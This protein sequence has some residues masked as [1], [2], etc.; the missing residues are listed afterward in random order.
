MSPPTRTAALLAALAV[1]AA[2]ATT[3]AI[4]E[5]DAARKATAK[6]G[7]AIRALITPSIPSQ[8]K[9]KVAIKVRVSTVNTRYALATV[10]GRRGYED[11]VQGAFFTLKRRSGVWK[12]LDSGS[13]GLGCALPA[14]VARDLLGD[15]ARD[16]C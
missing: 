11:V 9:T 8:W 5:A 2:G 7:A 12:V 1:V 10:G 3:A 4:G 6:E 16:G 14:R 13:T 15:L